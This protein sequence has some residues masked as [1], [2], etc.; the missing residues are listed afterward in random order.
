[1]VRQTLGT[2]F[3]GGTYSALF[4]VADVIA[5][6]PSVNGEINIDFDEAEFVA[7]FPLKG[8]NRIRLVRN[9]QDES[10]DL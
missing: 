10:A 5:D 9:G 6:G 2:G 4:Y 8:Q 7:I 1:M 3:P